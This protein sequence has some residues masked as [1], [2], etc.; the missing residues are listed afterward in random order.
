M[1]KIFDLSFIEI[2]R[3]FLKAWRF[4]PSFVARILAM[5]RGGVSASRSLR[6]A[7]AA[8]LALLLS[9]PLLSTSAEAVETTLEK[10]A[11]SANASEFKAANFKR[12]DD[13][14]KLPPLPKGKTRLA[15]K[16]GAIQAF[17]Q[18]AVLEY[19]GPLGLSATMTF[20]VRN[21]TYTIVA[22]IPIPFLKMRYESKGVV[23]DG[24][25]KPHRFLDLRNGKTYSSAKFD[26]KAGIVTFGRKKHPLKK[27]KITAPQYDFFSWAW[28]MAANG[29]NLGSEMQ[30]TNG[31]SAYQMG[32]M[33]HKLTPAEKSQGFV[34]PAAKRVEVEDSAKT[35]KA[36]W[37]S[38]S[39]GNNVM[40]VVMRDL[41]RPK[42]GDSDTIE[43]GFAPDFANA[44]VVINFGSGGTVYKLRAK[45]ITL[46]GVELWNGSISG[47]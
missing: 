5:P 28:D 38:V 40:L 26:W 36:K 17:P 11:S 43:F 2:M 35:A 46:D 25:L 39:G 4:L 15:P 44:P 21:G 12:M 37:A 31:K 14:L 27:Y 13:G 6:I 9:V 23:E 29:G 18:K 33:P 41:E 3:T 42:D 45:K 10:P 34:D 16:S 8:P 20:E 1:P 24:H 7:G 22:D 19:S 32:G 30:V 47:L